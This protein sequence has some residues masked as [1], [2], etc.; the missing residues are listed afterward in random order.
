MAST[1]ADMTFEKLH[2]SL[3]IQEEKNLREIRIKRNFLHI[4]KKMQMSTKRVMMDN[5]EALEVLQLKS[6]I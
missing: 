1:Y 5:N 2:Y 3:L 4:K 6:E